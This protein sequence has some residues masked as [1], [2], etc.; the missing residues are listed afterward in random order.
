M[1][2]PH[3]ADWEISVQQLD[4]LLKAG[5][6]FDLIDCRGADERALTSIEPSRLVPLPQFETLYEDAFAGRENR[7][8]I[9][10]CRA[11]VRSLDFARRLRAR[12]V[13][14]VKSVAGGINRWNQTFGDGPQY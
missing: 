3:D 12:G 11:G 5:A 13:A 14:D 2:D 10:Y 6:D 8:T 9:V 4:E 1:H 7:R